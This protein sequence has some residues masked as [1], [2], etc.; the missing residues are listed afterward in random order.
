MTARILDTS[1]AIA[2]Y[3]P[4]RYSIEA[5]VW[6]TALVE[7][8]ARLIVPGLHFWEMAN[9][10]RTYVR[11]GEISALVA[12]EIYTVHCE[13]GLEA[14]EPDKRSVLDVALNYDATAYDAVYVA[15]SLERQVPLLTAERTTTPW[16]VKLGKL[17]APIGRG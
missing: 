10:L 15:L 8:R 6:R 3:L 9:V 2:W 5:R 12:R 17:A 14:S 16:V 11:R 1:V 7:G 4:E 13:A